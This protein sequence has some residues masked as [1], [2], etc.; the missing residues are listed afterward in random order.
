MSKSLNSLPDALVNSLFQEWMTLK[1]LAELDTAF[2]NHTQR[3][4]ILDVILTVKQSTE[5]TKSPD[6]KALSK[7]SFFDWISLRGIRLRAL[8][9]TFKTL[10]R[11]AHYSPVITDCVEQISFP[12]ARHIRYNKNNAA[13]F[14]A[15]FTQLF[16]SCP[17]LKILELADPTDTFLCHCSAEIL[18]QLVSVILVKRNGWELNSLKTFDSIKDACQNLTT[19][20]LSPFV[21]AEIVFAI[22]DAISTLVDLTVELAD[23]SS[24]V[25][26]FEHLIATRS[27]IT[28]IHVSGYFEFEEPDFVSSIERFFTHFQ[29]CLTHFGIEQYGETIVLFDAYDNNVKYLKYLGLDEHD[30]ILAVLRAV[31]IVTRLELHNNTVLGQVARQYAGSLESLA[32]YEMSQAQAEE[33]LTV[34][35]N[36]KTVMVLLSGRMCR[37]CVLS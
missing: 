24:L 5:F 6:K 31:P 32:M 2:C 15:E 37:S 36:L 3:D 27:N 8:R 18:G 4:W 7:C 28:R 34:C 33:F 25:T 29:E 14:I 35:M 26:L 19:I 30:D 21:P 23:G 22:A 20:E 10:E 16:N 12:G 13:E 9:L 1:D 11:I 17:R